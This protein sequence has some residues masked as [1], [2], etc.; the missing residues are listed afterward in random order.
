MTRSLLPMAP[1]AG[2]LRGL[3][4]QR[5]E[6]DWQWFAIALLKGIGYFTLG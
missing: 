5:H 1:R 6:A 4:A 2:A 3:I